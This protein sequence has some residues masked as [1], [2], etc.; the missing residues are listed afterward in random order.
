[1]W[2]GNIRDRIVHACPQYRDKIEAWSGPG[3]SYNE[4][5]RD[6]I[7]RFVGVNYDV[8]QLQIIEDFTS[9]TGVNI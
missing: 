5:G 6:L 2:S 9:L 4:D 8:P 3:Y 1:M 7:L